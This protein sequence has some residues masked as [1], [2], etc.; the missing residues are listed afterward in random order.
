MR[1]GGGIAGLNLIDKV[2]DLLSVHVA[3]YRLAH[4]K[5]KS[6]SCTIKLHS[7]QH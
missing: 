6:K 2:F 3:A 1:T 5:G 4:G 7:I